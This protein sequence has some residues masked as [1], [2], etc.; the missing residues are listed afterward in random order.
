MLMR[1]QNIGLSII[2]SASIRMVVLD[3]ALINDKRSVFFDRVNVGLIDMLSH[4]LI[5]KG[6][7]VVHILLNQI[8]QLTWDFIPKNF[9]GWRLHPPWTSPRQESIFTFNNF[10]ILSYSTSSPSCIQYSR[11]CCLL[12]NNIVLWWFSFNIVI[13]EVFLGFS[14]CFS[15]YYL[16]QIDLVISDKQTVANIWNLMLIMQESTKTR[17]VVLGIV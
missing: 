9:I 1:H 11:R 13:M 15:S 5:R 14:V 8:A 16:I 4:L 2:K 7:M 3:L 17:S 6:I 10:G 12:A